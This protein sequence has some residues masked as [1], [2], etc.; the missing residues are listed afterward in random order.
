[1]TFGWLQPWNPLAVPDN[2][3]E[4]YNYLFWSGLHTAELHGMIYMITGEAYRGSAGIAFEAFTGH[5]AGALA[6]RAA[7][8]PAGMVG[9]AAVGA[10]AQH[11]AAAKHGAGSRSGQSFSVAPSMSIG[12]FDV[13]WSDIKSRFS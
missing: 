4:L 10:A 8:S 2:K 11:K 3:D 7:L 6:A 1:M 5:R 12:L 13:T 9:L